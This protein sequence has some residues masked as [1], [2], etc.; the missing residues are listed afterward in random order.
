MNDSY[1]L[2]RIFG[3]KVGVNWSVLLLLAFS[4]WSL[5][6]S[7]FPGSNP[8]LSDNTYFVMAVVTA[9]GFF[10]SS[11]FSVTGEE[12]SASRI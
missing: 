6:T 4:I 12:G 3:I 5:A 9:F 1:P 10:G 2:G 8:G 7:W 11:G